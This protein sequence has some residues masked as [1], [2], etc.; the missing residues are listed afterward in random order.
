MNAPVTANS[1][2]SHIIQINSSHWQHF[3]LSSC[4]RLVSHKG[5]PELFF[6]RHL[7]TQLNSRRPVDST[8]V[9]GGELLTY[10]ALL[11][12]FRH[13][14]DTAS[15]RREPDIL[16][17]GLQT[18]GCNPFSHEVTA[19]LETF[20]TLFPPTDPSSPDR[21]SFE[22]GNRLHHHILLRELL[23]LRLASENR[24]LDS[25]REL[26]DDSQLVVT[27]PLYTVLISNIEAALEHGEL[28]PG[29]S[30]TLMAAL[31]MPISNN[32]NSLSGQ[33]D[34][35]R[36][37]WGKILPPELLGNVEYAFDV[38]Q[39]EAHG[40]DM[41]GGEPPAPPVMEFGTGSAA[42]GHHSGASVFGGYDYPEHEA[43]SADADWMPHLVLMAKMV[44]VWLDQLSRQYAY[45]ITQLDQ[46]PE[47]ELAAMARRGFS[48]LWLIGVWERSPA[49]QRIKELCGNHDAIASAYSLYD[50]EIAA[51]LGGWDALA[52]L[53]ERALRHGIRLASD[54]VPNHTGIYSRWVL[55]HPDWFVQT[56]YPPFPTYKFTGEDL[57]RSGDAVIQLEDGYWTKSDAA[58]VFR[59]IERS[60]GRTRYLYHGNDGTTIPWNDTAQLNYLLP[61]VRE[62]VIQTILH[63][64]RNFPI[65]RFDAA[66]TLAKKHYQRLW[67]PIRGLGG[68][69]PS[70]SEHG[71]NRDEFDA[72]FPVE[73]W[74]EV[75][76]RVA[77]EVPGT[78]LLAEAFWLMEGYFVRTLG[79]HRVYNS[80]FMN[81]LMKEEN[82]K[83]RQTVKNVLAFNPEVLQRFV[84]FMN[85]PDEKT[86]LEQFGSEGKYFGSCL[87]L[88]TMPGLPMFGHGQIEGYREKYG[89]EYKRAYW[90]EPLDH[91]LIQG[92][93]MW[94]FPILRKR[95]LFSGA[96]NFALYD[97]MTDVGVDENVYAY[98]NRFQDERALVLFN[99]R[100]GKTAGWIRESSPIA[101]SSGDNPETGTVTLS[102]ALGIECD[103]NLYYAFH[104]HTRGLEYIRSSMELSQRGLYAE[105]GEYEFH[106]F[107]NFRALRDNEGDEISWGAF[108]SALNGRGVTNLEDELKQLRYPAVNDTFRKVMELTSEIVEPWHELLLKHF[109]EPLE[110]SFASTDGIRILFASM[111]MHGATAGSMTA[112]GLDYTLRFQMTEEMAPRSASLVEAVCA[113]SPLPIETWFSNDAVRTY[114]LVHSSGGTVWFNK[115]RFEELLA[116]YG[117]V[118]RII[119]GK[120]ITATLL[121]TF[122]KEY[123][124]QCRLAQHA[125]YRVELFKTL[126]TQPYNG[127]GKISKKRLVKERL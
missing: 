21:F 11:T 101:I 125:G 62:A 76:D 22:A 27:A 45:P 49:S 38:L 114:L 126:L 16:V 54:M 92:H 15:F 53:R 118:S 71:M 63:V 61:E 68:G 91:G 110:S 102:H 3:D 86:A 36:T 111:L 106:I 5:I 47:A 108:C 100:H 12:V 85:N 94:I 93:E 79:M 28:L 67:Y 117:F 75:V 13:L 124:A 88:T 127:V 96:A 98:S 20:M 115:E 122:K 78:L 56:D 73:F 113:I 10:A 59:M 103:A 7:A 37:Q 51:D 80:A 64:A 99:N 17:E 89:M 39:E 50:Y 41:G 25:F 42:F 30:A 112:L 116:W 33:L 1:Y 97:F 57:S 87:L 74:R 84:N 35:V 105:L 46:I 72:M 4:A 9:S 81:M 34:F 82:A 43:F 58:V 120:K 66:M 107:S 83:Y 19:T 8:M 119:S 69:I 65:I 90:D 52:N 23:L 2:F 95:A 55:H 6:Y 18:V 26:L 40:W 104:D 123:M 77:L 48:G 60:T 109:G 24:S 70:R 14:I 31:R 32:P 44:Y 121:T 29:I